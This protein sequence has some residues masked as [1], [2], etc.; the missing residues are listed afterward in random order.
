MGGHSALPHSLS[1]LSSVRHFPSQSHGIEHIH[2]L[3]AGF[4]Q[5]AAM[6][7]SRQM[8]PLRVR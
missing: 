4:I 7:V 1:G 6:E 8:L 5:D 2:A 3:G